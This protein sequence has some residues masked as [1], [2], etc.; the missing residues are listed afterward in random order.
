MLK[1][2]KLPKGTPQWLT[3]CIFLLGACLGLSISAHTLLALYGLS[4]FLTNLFYPTSEFSIGP[5]EAIYL[6]VLGLSAALS[7]TMLSFLGVYMNRLSRKAIPLSQIMWIPLS[8][9]ALLVFWGHRIET[10]DYGVPSIWVLAV[11]ASIVLGGILP[12]MLLRTK[13]A[14]KVHSR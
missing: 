1:Y 12:W 13:A 6:G 3:T 2:K 8:V 4:G 5:S 11:F 14:D 10:F 7:A 9:T